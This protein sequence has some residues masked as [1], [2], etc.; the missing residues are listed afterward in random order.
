MAKVGERV[1]ERQNKECFKE[2]LLE[3]SDG[4][5]YSFYL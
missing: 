3:T 1:T 2:N 5:L 4:K